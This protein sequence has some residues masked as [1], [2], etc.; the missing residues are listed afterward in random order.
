MSAF[1]LK[2]RS[3][4]LFLPD[5][6]KSSGNNDVDIKIIEQSYKLWPEIERGI[7]DTSFLQMKENDL[8]LEVCNIGR[9]RAI[10]G[11]KIFWNKF[12]E[13]V[14]DNDIRTF[15]MGSM[16]GAILIQRGLI[17][18]H[19]NALEKNGKTIVCL[20]FSGAGK[21]TLAY[22][23]L[24]NGWKFISDDLVAI[25]NE[26]YILKGIPRL[27]LW[28]DCLN[29]FG[30]NKTNLKTVR[31]NINKYIYKPETKYLSKYNSKPSAF[32]VINRFSRKPNINLED[33][34]ETIN[35]EQ[36]KFLYLRNNLYRPRFVRGLKKEANLFIKL[37]DLQ[38]NVPVSFLNLPTKIN[39]LM[40]LV[41][42]ID[43]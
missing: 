26:G 39:F 13:K 15:L 7:A 43:L 37:A 4:D 30:I 2:W 12:D 3:D 33:N 14:D 16:F 34:I 10:N 41:K 22:A 32:Y 6:P 11:N 17:L 1:D 21:S 24:Q 35:N 38:K 23:L 5:M 42:K 19:G 36:I 31:N 40:D 27:K 25:N 28:E 20:G 18:M 29:F 8:R 9:F